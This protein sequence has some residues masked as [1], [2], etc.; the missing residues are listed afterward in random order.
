MDKFLYSLVFIFC[1]FSINVKSQD[2][3]SEI[4]SLVQRV[5]SLEHELSYLKLTYELNSL[6]SD[7]LI[8]V[9]DIKN[10]VMEI[11]LNIYNRNFDYDLYNS[12]KSYYK[13]CIRKKETL[14]GL[15]DVKK[16]YFTVKVV[17]F[18]FSESEMDILMSNYR[19]I[20]DTYDV[21]EKS[22]NLFE[23]VV[24]AYRDLL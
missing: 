1:F 13:S 10:E 17:T 5:D 2:S 21:L 8:F 22:I 12:Y 24:N 4:Q 3:I 6:N 9:N 15:I 7:I 14:K 16:Y 18:P 11:R 19:L 20:D 23:V